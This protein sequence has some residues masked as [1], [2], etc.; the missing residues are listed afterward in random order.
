MSITKRQR[1]RAMT[2]LS[3]LWDRIDHPLATPE[4]AVSICREYGVSSP[5]FARA[6]PEMASQ[7]VISL[8]A[9][10][11]EIAKKEGKA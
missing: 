10:S 4:E 6:L 11:V 9:I 5:A 1:Q 7:R 3:E 2:V 8:S